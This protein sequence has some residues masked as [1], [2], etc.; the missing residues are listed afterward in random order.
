MIIWDL[1]SRLTLISPL[2]LPS[3]DDVT[4][5]IIKGF[6]DGTLPRHTIWSLFMVFSGMICGLAG[7]IIMSA[8]SLFSKWLA[9]LWDLLTVLAHPLPGL[10]LLPLLILWTG[11]GS[12]IIFLIVLH[13]VL[14]PLYLNLDSS[15]RNME[16]LW[17]QVARNNEM[18]NIQ[19]LRR[20]YLPASWIA[21]ISGLRISWARAWRAAVGAEMI[22]GAMGSSAGLGW[23]IFNARLFMDT[24]ALFAGLICLMTAGIIIEELLFKK[25]EVSFR[26]KY[27]YA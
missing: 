23:Y 11:I 10:A 24:Q 2:I 27:N 6:R 16:P 18:S 8:G 20:I 3:P 21:L 22:F 17:L 12:H 26:E 25:L 13:S 7:A 9:S 15:F 19:I 5:A 4:G 14:W 1:T